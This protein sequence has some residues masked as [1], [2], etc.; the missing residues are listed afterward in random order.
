[1]ASPVTVGCAA[2]A[3][4]LAAVAAPELAQL[5]LPGARTRASAVVA[6]AMLKARLDGAER[7]DICGAF[8][9][10]R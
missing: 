7:W 1:L 6:A 8:P 3:V 2:F 5:M 10:H 4:E 9:V